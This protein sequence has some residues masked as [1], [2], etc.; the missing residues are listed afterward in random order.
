MCLVFCLVVSCLILIGSSNTQ[1]AQP[2]N[3]SK[4]QPS[5]ANELPAR[6]V[7]WT[8][9]KVKGSPDPPLRYVA[10]RVF[11]G[12]ELARPV[13][14]GWLSDANCW[15][16]SHKGGKLVRFDN[17]PSSAVAEPL[18][19]V[20]KGF[21]SQVRNVYS[22]IMHP[23]QA[24]QPWCFVTFLAEPKL[25]DGNHLARVRVIDS[26]IPSFDLES[27]EVLLSWDSNGH[28]GGSMQFGPDGM[29]Y[30]SIGDGQRP[31][32]P[33]VNETGQDLT[34]LESSVLRIDVD[35]PTVESPYRIPDDNPFVGQPGVREEIWA[36]GFRNPWKIAF[37]PT[38]GDL[39]AADVGWEMR[40][41]IH[42]VQRGRNHGWSIKEGSQP[43]KH[44]IEPKIPITPPLFEHNHVDSRSI[45]GGHYW[46]S[47]RLPELMGAYLYGDW[48]TGKV[49]ALKHDGDEVLWQK[50]LVDTPLQIIS[51]MLDPSG[52]VLVVAYD[53]TILRLNENPEAG[54]I[55][56]FPKRLSQTGI[57]SDVQQQVP[58]EGVI[59]YEISAHHWAD[60]TTSRQ[61][62][63]LPE[64]TRLGIIDRDDWT[65]GD[66]AGRFIFPF[67]T[68]LA[69]TVYYQNDVMDPASVRRLETQILHRY[70][71]D[72]R[73]YNYVWNDDQTDA[74]LQ[75]D[76]ATERK[77]VIKDPC[78]EGGQR[79][80]SWRHS[81]RSECLLCHIWAGGTAHAFWPDQLN[82]DIGGDNQMDRLRRMGLFAE[83]M[84]RPDPVADPHD[85]SRT[86]EDRA[87]SYLA[88]NCSTCHRKQGGGTA[89]FNFD[90][91]KSL[92][93][94][95]YLDAVPAQGT[96][97]IDDAK[98]V[99][100][101]DPLSS[102][103]LYRALKTGRGH[104]PQFGS[105]VLD[106]DGIMLLHD[107]IASM[108]DQGQ[109][110]VSSQSKE[111]VGI[112]IVGEVMESNDR[113]M[114]IREAIRT[115]SGA[116]A[117]SLACHDDSL[118]GDF[119]DLVVAIGSHSD[120]P[121]IR[122]LF[123]HFLPED[124]RVVRLGAT[125]DSEALLAM[126]GSAE[127]GKQ[128]FETAADVNCRSC[129]R[130]GQ[131]GL[132]VGPDLKDVCAKQKPSGIL[133]SIVYP[134]RKIAPEYQGTQVLT[135]QGK[136]VVGIVRSQTDQ[137]I[138]LVDSTG[139]EHRIATDDIEVLK[140]LPQSIMPEKLLTGMTPQQAADLLAY[141]GGGRG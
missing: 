86:V 123:E 109:Q 116:M 78:A 71:E 137:W 90:I 44:G 133:E 37:D 59:E 126:T 13:E 74:V 55:S 4:V 20:A 11:S 82:V 60:G 33:D 48:M 87:R 50:E 16:A 103:L 54:K 79:S 25:I 130:L 99:C 64:D 17:D 29:L 40:E 32:P 62:V 101:G 112:R 76:V 115:T 135:V 43:V 72:W 139:K 57:F 39:L 131:V 68:V 61:W 128:L 5:A 119:R 118:D 45:S 52:E 124:R 26:A 134:S 2:G 114:A 47:P 31:Y 69:K 51:F 100:S 30:L 58:S 35:D 92:A 66:T 102:V 9:S 81:S 14:I 84:P 67:D 21:G 63:A 34:D 12:V 6:Q 77:L 19:D 136:V 49:W 80:Q 97:A 93:E 94:N 10:E 127:R 95:N 140:K 36:F 83:S 53:G 129:H 141:L 38:S 105:S 22:L 75:D 120:A 104:M 42:R 7:P 41:M 108:G 8:S 117:L 15:V 46:T 24:T 88:L 70:D 65:T 107:W 1:A 85:E 56:S 28:S 125:I 113:E 121:E 138:S 122:D 96:F 89:D 111:N 3:E 27:F 98:V 106:K 91:T 23:D 132:N 110:G 18:F 73:A